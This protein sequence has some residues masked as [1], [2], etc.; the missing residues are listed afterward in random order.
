MVALKIIG[1]IIKALSWPFSIVVF[2][3][4]ITGLVIAFPFAYVSDFLVKISNRLLIKAA[5]M[6][7]DKNV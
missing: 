2:V 7:R 6:E 4:S 5:F 1:N 3:L